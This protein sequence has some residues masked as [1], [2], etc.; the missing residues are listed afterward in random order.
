MVLKHRAYIWLQMLHCGTYWNFL[1][2]CF[3][4]FKKKLE[5]ILMSI[6]KDVN[7]I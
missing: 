1:G 5:L 2:V 4:F 6:L 3:P 7:N